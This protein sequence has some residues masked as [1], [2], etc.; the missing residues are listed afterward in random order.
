MRKKAIAAA[1]VLGAI[2]TAG[3]FGLKKNIDVSGMQTF[4][5]EHFRIHYVLLEETT[6][7]DIANALETAYPRI[8]AFFAVER[9]PKSAVVVYPGAEEF[10]HAYL[11]HLLARAYGDWA[12]GAAYETMVLCASPENPGSQHTYDDILQILVHEY[13]HTRIYRINEFPNVWLD[14][15]LATYL[16]G[17]ESA[18]PEILP[19]FEAFNQDDTGAFLD[20][21][22]YAVA[23]SF[24]AYLDRTYGNEKILE[25]IRTNDYP[26]AFGKTAQ[27]VY[28]DWAREVRNP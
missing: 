2:L 16:A 4:E 18:L 22:G 6:K 15:G 17:Q 3:Y 24:I 5:T 1:L 11:G 12:A 20:H 19:D 23:Y 9:E 13:V 10:Q 8:A 25:L 21:D 7:S 14:E 26:A 27:A 28:A